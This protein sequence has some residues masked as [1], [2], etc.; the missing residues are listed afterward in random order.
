MQSLTKQLHECLLLLKKYRV[1]HRKFK[2]DTQNNGWTKK[3]AKIFRRNSMIS[4]IIHWL[5]QTQQILPKDI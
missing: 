1:C 5:D 4:Q 2:S 3:E